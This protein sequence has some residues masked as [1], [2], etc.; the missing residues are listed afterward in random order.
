MLQKEGYEIVF[1]DEVHKYNQWSQE[2]KNLYDAFPGLKI[3]FSG[4][5]M[6]DLVHVSG[7]LS[8]RAKMYYLKGLSFREYLNFTMNENFEYFSLQE[9]FEYQ[10]ILSGIP[11]IYS[12]FKA[13]LQNG[14]YPFV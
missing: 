4:S 10:N 14:Y 7:D 13:Y 3:V 5:S 2:L 9:L 11:Q 1:I 8:R 12:H 6:L